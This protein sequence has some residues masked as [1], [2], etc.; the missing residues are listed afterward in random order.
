MT[1]NKKMLKKQ[2]V[3]YQERGNLQLKA[4]SGSL[5]HG[6]GCQNQPPTAPQCNIENMT[7]NV[8]YKEEA[9]SP[10]INRKSQRNTKKNMWPA[11][12]Q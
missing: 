11:I 5:A 2:K 6:N 9:Y 7:L 4:C 12:R 10:E 8:I 1:E 3:L